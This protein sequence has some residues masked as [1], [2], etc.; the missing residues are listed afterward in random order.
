[1]TRRERRAVTK[2]WQA[3]FEQWRLDSKKYGQGDP[4]NTL[5]T[6]ELFENCEGDNPADV[7]IACDLLE[8]LLDPDEALSKMKSL[9]RKQVCFIIETDEIRSSEMWKSVIG[10]YFPVARITP[11]QGRKI[12]IN[13]ACTHPFGHG[14][15]VAAGTNEGR[16]DN[17]RSNM[18]L[19][20]SRVVSAEP[21]D[22]RALVAC[23]GP[24]IK[25]NMDLLIRDAASPN[26]DVI[27]V[28]GSH[29][30][31]IGN[32]VIPKFHVECDPRPH[33][34]DNIS[35]GISG[36]KYL[37]GSCVHP[38]LTEKLAGF[39]L[40]LWHP[41]GE[42]NI[43][44]IDEIEPDATFVASALNVGLTSLTLFYRLGYREFSIYGMDCSFK[45]EEM[46][47]GP[48]A[49]KKNQ[50]EHIIVQVMCGGRQFSTSMI[51]IAYANAFFDLIKMMPD[52][53]FYICGDHLLQ[54]MSRIAMAQAEAA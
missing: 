20:K 13:A 40:S 3:L 30:F 46:W 26:A 48:H 1:M 10:K 50:K 24:S 53:H 35:K 2:Q 34:A 42:F 38:V 12:F 37:L 7:L 32:G 23:Y 49:Q 15:F 51:Y 39:D 41:S 52:A 9:A 4:F 31:L 27:S 17:I 6:F 29:D 21:H 19:I 36:V 45:G 14:K 11:L 54:Q 33:K 43:K 47:A 28:S 22:R 5:E 44:I 25:D 18:E 8:H 16:W